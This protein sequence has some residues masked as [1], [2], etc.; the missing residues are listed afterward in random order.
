MKVVL[1]ANQYVSAV[2]KPESK[3][4]QLVQL[5]L[6]KKVTI[7]ASEP[8]LEEIERVL[9]YPKLQKVHN[10]APEEVS[11]YVQDIR[12]AAMIT[13]AKLKL[14]AVKKDPADDKYL[15]CAVEG[16][17]DYIVSGDHHLKDLALYRGIPILD[18]ATFLQIL[19]R[20]D[21]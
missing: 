16:N 1:D 9:S 17:A 4:A 7:L 5:A 15:V 19:S 6:K 12:E 3:P 2:L 11:Q 10:F 21:Q 20:S 8:I 18:P 13:P 14:Q